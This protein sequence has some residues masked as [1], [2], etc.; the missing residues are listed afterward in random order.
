M[1]FLHFEINIIPITTKILPII[2]FNSIFDLK[3]IIDK[4]NV[5]KH[6]LLIIAAL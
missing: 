6:V 3:Y 4:N 5:N 2:P 1:L